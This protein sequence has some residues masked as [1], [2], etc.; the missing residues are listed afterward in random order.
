MPP[1]SGRGLTDRQLAFV[2]SHL[3][4]QCNAAMYCT[5][6]ERPA[7]QYSQCFIL[8]YLALVGAP[9]II[10]FTPTAVKWL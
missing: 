1:A 2:I 5:D 8:I 4:M 6:F 3:Y 7:Y 9:P 10:L